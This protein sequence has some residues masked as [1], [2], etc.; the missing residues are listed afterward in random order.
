MAEAWSPRDA[1]VAKLLKL[2]G[3]VLRRSCRRRPIPGYEPEDLL[4]LASLAVLDA[5][6]AYQSAR[7]DFVPLVLAERLFPAI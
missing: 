1:H 7:G 5:V 3:P 4:Q 2:L 6:K